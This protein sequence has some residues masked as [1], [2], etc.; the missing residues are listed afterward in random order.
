VCDETIRVSFSY[1]FPR[2]MLTQV[3]YGAVLRGDKNKIILGSNSNVQDRAVIS[4]VPSLESGFPADVKIGEY[5]TIGH[6]ALIT[7]S[8]IGN[9]VLI[10]QGAIIEAGC[11]VEDQ[12]MVAA[13]AVVLPGTLI[14]TGEMWAGNPAK[15][16]RK[17]SEDETKF[18][19]AVS[20]NY[21]YA[22]LRSSCNPALRKRSITCSCAFSFSYLTNPPTSLVT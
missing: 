18:L 22:H 7:S 10:G 4:T 20:T 5:V 6:G 8:T 19:E 21:I 1:F 3:F 16:V 12:S 15:F 17:L 14:K 2:T 9:R 13:G 11:V